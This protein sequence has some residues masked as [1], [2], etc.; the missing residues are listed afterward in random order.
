[1]ELATAVRRVF[2]VR[3]E[4][5]NI[6]SMHQN[7]SVNMSLNASV[8]SSYSQSPGKDERAEAMREV[9]NRIEGLN[10]ILKRTGE[11]VAN[12]GDLINRIDQNLS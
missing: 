12:Q 10:A 11:V 9:S 2:L 7:V 4:I 3:Q 8:M 1:M 6:E 5:S